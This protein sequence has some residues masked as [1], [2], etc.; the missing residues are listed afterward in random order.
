V[1]GPD[2]RLLLHEIAFGLFMATMWARLAWAQGLIAA[3]TL[4]YLA[5]IVMN[6]VVIEW[7]WQRPGSLGRWRLRLLYYAITM[8]LLFQHM[9]I[10]IPAIH[11]GRMDA[12]LLAIDRALTGETPA[13]LLQAWVRPWLTDLLSFCYFLFLPYL[14]FSLV[15]YLFAPL[16]LAQRFWVGLFT[17]YG[18]GFTGYSLVPAIGP[19]S[20]LAGQ[21]T[22]PL[23]GNALTTFMAGVIARGSNGVDVFPSLHCAVSAYLLL[24][25]RRYKPLRFKLYVVPCVLL[26]V[27]TLYLRYHYLID[28]IAG[29]VLTAIALAVAR[30]FTPP[31]FTRKPAHDLHPAL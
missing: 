5:A 25:D 16:A 21:F 17:L 20:Y 18:I 7:S 19:W 27:S 14:F 23:T 22:V 29:F 31:D 28:L 15:L 8:N 12:P 4:V 30:R 26:W 6:V 9:R 24:F 11:P 1:C 3:P 13:L 2:R 10:A